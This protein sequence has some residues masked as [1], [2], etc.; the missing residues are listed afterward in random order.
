VGTAVGDFI[1][2][3]S[4]PSFLSLVAE[5]IHTPWKK[6]TRL[7]RVS[8]L[9]VR[10]TWRRIHASFALGR[11]TWL[12]IG[13]S[14]VRIAKVFSDS[15]VGKAAAGLTTPNSRLFWPRSPRALPISRSDSYQLT[16]AVWVARHSLTQR[17]YLT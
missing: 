6:L 13:Q 11:K 8:E 1:R 16:P 3:Y 4:V 5:G 10:L 17:R 12:H 2:F 9:R 7:L 15:L 14:T